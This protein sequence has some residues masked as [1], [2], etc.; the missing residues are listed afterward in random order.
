MT[1]REWLSTLT[2]EEFA[3]WLTGEDTYNWRDNEFYGIYPHRR[4]I[5]RQYASSYLGI[6]D[7]L[8]KPRP[9]SKVKVVKELPKE[10]YDPSEDN[11][12]GNKENTE[13]GTEPTTDTE[14]KDSTYQE[15]QA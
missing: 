15:N 10:W 1:N 7:W 11:L 12:Y 5:E 2:D 9:Y 13:E 6:L 3:D 14:K 4:N 8:G